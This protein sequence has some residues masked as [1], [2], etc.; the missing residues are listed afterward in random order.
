MRAQGKRG[1]CFGADQL[2]RKN[3]FTQKAPG[4]ADNPSQSCNHLHLEEMIENRNGS[5]RS[6]PTNLGKCE[7]ARANY[8]AHN[9][10]ARL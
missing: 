5:V 4:N 9:D 1:A 7:E 8:F 6:V 10:E 3:S 2:N